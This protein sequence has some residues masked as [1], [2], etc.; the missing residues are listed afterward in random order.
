MRNDLLEN[1]RQQAELADPSVRAAALLWIAR[2]ESA[3]DTSRACQSL[4]EGLAAI[5]TLPSSTGDYLF[6]EARRVAAA[7][8]PELLA[9]I[10]VPQHDGPAQFWFMDNVAIVQTMLAHRHADAAFN[11]VLHLNDPPSFPFLSVG[12]VL[13]RLDPHDP[14]HSA[15][16]MMLLHHSVELWRQSRSGGP[17]TEQG[18]FVGCRDGFLGL[19]GHSWKDFPPEEALSI[20]RMIVD[21]AAQE[22]DIGT[23]S[24]YPDDIHFFSPRQDTL[25]QILHVLRHLDPALTQAL[26]DEHDQLALAARRYPNGLETM[27]EEAQ[28]EADRR[29]AESSTACEGGTSE[30]GGYILTGNPRDSDRLRGIMDAARSGDFQPAIEDATVKYREDSSPDAP[31]YAPK[32]YW[33]STAAFRM[34]FHDAGRRL[35][36]DS[37]RLLEQ[38][39]DNDL[40]LFA[41]IELAAALAGLPAPQTLSMKRRRHPG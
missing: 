33:P 34:L 21:R 27:N 6:R 35:G 30:C 1:A 24:G 9:E 13:G 38:I 18:R 26:M 7:V 14:E 32:E 20:V 10:P 12:A 8:S 4:L 23:S 11:Y 3:G 15:H 40:R 17:Q 19:F 22:P 31:N 41:S 39:P 28:A 29:K 16:R 5:R 25:F 2:V 36:S 37:A